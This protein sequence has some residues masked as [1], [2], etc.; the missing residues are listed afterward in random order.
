MD[1][2]NVSIKTEEEIIIQRDLYLLC[3]SGN[4]DLEKHNEPP[5]TKKDRE[6]FYSELRLTWEP[7][8]FRGNNNNK[9]HLDS[10][11]KSF[12]E[13]GYYALPIFC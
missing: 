9:K 12:N 11:R 10:F 2:N 6:D 5:V 3:V 8:I 4:N 1:F 13:G 7:Y